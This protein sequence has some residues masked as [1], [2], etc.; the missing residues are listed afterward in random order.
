MQIR[1]LFLVSSCLAIAA[2][3]G[4]STGFL[5]GRQALLR[6]EPDNAVAYFDRVA[7]A[8]PGYIA[9]SPPPRKSIWTYVGRAHYNSGRYAEAK[10]AY[11]KALTRLKDDYVARLYR[12]LTLLR[13]Q[14]SAPPANVFTL[15]EVSYALREGVAPRRVGTLARERG[16]AFDLNAE[17]ES[18]LKNS[19]ADTI[20][21]D[22]LRK[23]RAERAKQ[24]QPS[25]N[26]R[27]EGA[28]EITTALTGLRDWLDYTIASTTQGRFWDPS[29][30]IRAEISRGLRA[31][32]ASP[33]DWEAILTS[34][35]S[36][37]YKLEEEGDRARRDEAEDFQRRRR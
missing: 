26:Q 23:L 3:A 27:N 19:G 6:G 2:C 14:P 22:D 34:A 10:V 35:E 18:Q 5:A 33:R 13:V 30:E 24:N 32:T 28:K 7:Q 17:T 8:D 4:S 29:G 15:Q 31:T 20:L 9:D 1:L 12:G 11:D 37:G 21:L 16:I 25:D 36:V